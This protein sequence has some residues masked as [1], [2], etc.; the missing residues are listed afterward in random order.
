MGPIQ[1]GQT[2]AHDVPE[3]QSSHWRQT[4]LAPQSALLVQALQV[5]GLRQAGTPS[6]VV[7]QVQS[8]SLLQAIHP[9]TQVCWPAAQVPAT[10]RQAPPTQVSGEVQP[11]QAPELSQTP[12]GTLS[13]GVPAA[14]SG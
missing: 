14:A 8:L 9:D 1:S 4:W 2:A 13:Q 6:S 10:E 5:I 3:K 7:S 11:R 12:Q